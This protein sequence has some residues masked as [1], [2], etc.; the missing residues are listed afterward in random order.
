MTTAQCPTCHF[1]FS[2]AAGRVEC[3]KC[4]EVFHPARPKPPKPKPPS[5]ADAPI[6]LAELVDDADIPVVAPVAATPSRVRP[7]AK[8]VAPPKPALPPPAERKTVGTPRVRQRKEK[9]EPPPKPA[10]SGRKLIAGAVVGLVVIVGVAIGVVYALR[11]APPPQAA[12]PAPA[13]APVPEPKPAD[14]PPVV[15][16]KKK[17]PG[18]LVAPAREVVEIRPTAA[19]DGTEIALW[20]P[21]DAV[22]V[23]GGGRFLLLRVPKDRLIAVFDATE[24]KIVKQLPLTEPG[25]LIA[26]GMT[27]LYVVLPKAAAI[28]RWDLRTF[29]LESTDPIP[30]GGT[31][32]AALMGHLTEG[33]LVLLGQITRF[34]DPLT[35]AVH[36]VP[37]KGRTELGGYPSHTWCS[38]DGRV[39]AWRGTGGSPSGVYTATLGPDGAVGHSRHESWGDPLPTADGTVVAGNG[40]FASDLQPIGDP[41]PKFHSW[42][43][44]PS[45]QGPF[46]LA[47]TA[48]DTEYIARGDPPP[49]GLALKVVGDS[50]PLATIETPGVGVLK[51]NRGTLSP[52]LHNR[53]FLVPAA[54]LLVVLSQD[55]A[56]LHLHAFDLKKHLDESELD[57]LTVLSR[58]HPATA[59]SPYR[60]EPRVASKRGGVRV[61]LESGPAGMTAAG[62]VVAWDVPAGYAGD[63]PVVL[64]ISD[65]T[66][67]ETRHAF[68]LAA[69]PAGSSQPAAV[70]PDAVAAVTPKPAPPPPDPTTRTRTP[71]KLTAAR[72]EIPLTSSLTGIC[73]AGGGHI[74]L[75][76]QTNAE[77]A[78]FDAR[79]AAVVKHLPLPG[80]YAP[81]AGGRD[82]VFVYRSLANAIERWNLHTLEKELTVPSPVPWPIERLILGADSTG[83]LI[84]VG[85]VGYDKFSALIDTKTLR[86]VGTAMPKRGASMYPLEKAGV[87]VSADGRIITCWSKDG[88][89]QSHSSFRLAADGTYTFSPL[90]WNLIGHAVPSPDGKHVYT[91]MGVYRVGPDGVREIP[92]LANEFYFYTLPPAEPTPLFLSVTSR[93]FPHGMDKSQ[94]E[95][96]LHLPGERM[97]V[98]TLTDVTLPL[99]I[100]VWGREHV[101]VV[102]RVHMIPSA[103]A[104]VVVPFEN[105]KLVMHRLNLS[106]RLDKTGRDYLFVASS[107]PPTAAAGK[108]FRYVL[109]V[110]SKAGSA[111]VKLDDGPA[112]MKVAGNTV[113]WNV[114]AAFDAA[115]ASVRLSVTDASGKTIPHAFEVSVVRAK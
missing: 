109:D 33:P 19:V 11:T 43:P 80:G 66:G 15:V 87:G 37:F 63:A 21:A 53:V 110:K 107:P 7:V 51:N 23:G 77:L 31:P 105:D 26:A 96:H 20:S 2:P 65:V 34:L 55:R 103:D 94:P 99:G 97:P 22:C 13:P 100:G 48:W 16:V 83:P 70:F 10:R 111:A 91:T 5:P 74:L 78:V 68:T 101:A 104:V 76:R 86:N 45:T 3:P 4:L 56:K 36:D 46:Y 40:V 89:S 28:E 12:A 29:A 35:L 106:E 47:A 62:N 115:T 112:G 39:F 95:L 1:R 113:L 67:Q 79:E 93:G 108:Q 75:V 54:K 102:D 14:P 49:S 30:L 25:G 84:A 8:V 44:A 71:P 98:A 52:P 41:F 114:P 50:R 85:G 38:A 61:K 32:Q 24:G 82:H 42:T 17:E 59:G 27:K 73:R 60:Y 57:Y 6:P 72:K 18:P 58:P 92:G 81:F 88:G 90:Q 9:E 64:T 69:G